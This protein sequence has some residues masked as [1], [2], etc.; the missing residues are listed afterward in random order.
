M[1]K[2]EIIKTICII[3]LIV[4]ATC[5]LVFLGVKRSKVESPKLPQEDNKKDENTD[6]NTENNRLFKYVLDHETNE[7]PIIYIYPEREINLSV[8]LLKD[9]KIIHSYPKYENVWNVIAKPDGTLIDLTT[10]RELY[11]L[12]YECENHNTYD[13]TDEGFVVKGED[14]VSF[15]EEKLEILGLNAREAEEFIIYWSPKL[16]ENKYN[17]IRFATK[18]EIEDDMPIE[19][20]IK[21]D[22]QIRVLMTYKPL[23]S[24]IEVKEQELTT[25]QRTGFTVVEWGG[26][27][28][29]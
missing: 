6:E 16:E 28:I 13:I 3:I 26:S 12:Y 29:K 5:G 19:Y 18:E 22:C 1:K 23:E 21:P 17:Y 2:S 24:E 11:S 8:K 25:P 27:L 9:D 10:N 14:I 4:L 7:K 20:S 15:L